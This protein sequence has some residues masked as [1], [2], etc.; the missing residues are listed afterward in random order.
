MPILKDQI[1]KGMLMAHMQWAFWSLLMMPI[2]NIE[3]CME[4]YFEYA[5]TRMELYFEHMKLLMN[6]ESSIPH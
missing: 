5:K 4:F 3:K 6:K 1:V 2:E